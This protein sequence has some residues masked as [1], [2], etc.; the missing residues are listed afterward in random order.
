MLPGYPAD[1]CAS[2]ACVVDIARTHQ[3]AFG[4]RTYDPRLLLLTSYHTNLVQKAV[5]IKLALTISHIAFTF[6]PHSHS[7]SRSHSHSHS[8]SHSHSHSHSHSQPRRLSI[9]PTV[10]CTLLLTHTIDKISWR[11]TGILHACMSPEPDTR[12]RERQGEGRRGKQAKERQGEDRRW[13]CLLL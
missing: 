12:V 3:A 9:T 2:S 11:D 4:H 7:H 8:R 6:T 10:I 13:R 5:P 1:D